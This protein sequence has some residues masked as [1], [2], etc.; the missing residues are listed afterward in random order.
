MGASTT[1]EG[2]ETSAQL[3][4]ARRLEIT[5]GQGYLLGR[6]GPERDL[7]WVD[8]GALEVRDDVAIPIRDL[9]DQA[10]PSGTIAER[11]A[12]WEDPDLADEAGVAAGNGRGGMRLPSIAF[13]KASRQQPPD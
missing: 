1:A 9:S 11:L 13:L 3:R 7:T 4:T 2:I 8:I 6:P 10:K 12:T 5:N